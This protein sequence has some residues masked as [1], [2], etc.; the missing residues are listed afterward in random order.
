MQVSW[1]G[2][3][4]PAGLSY[5]FITVVFVVSVR[6]ASFPNMISGLADFREREI[7]VRE[8]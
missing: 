8:T 1:Q 2:P 5:S 3:V 6:V 4:A 7:L